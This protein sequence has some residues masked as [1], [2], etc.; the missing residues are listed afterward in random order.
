[1]DYELNLN[2]LKE[3]ELGILKKFDQICRENNLEYSLAYGTMLGAVR[4]HG[5]IPWD[6]DIDV[7]MKRDDYEKLM[8]LQYEDEQYEV[9]SYRYTK[10]YYYPF[11][12]MID[13]TTCL[14]E[15][16]RA[17]K[18]MGVYIDIFPLDLIN[19]FNEE[20]KATV[21]HNSSKK[22]YFA[23]LMG[24]KLS[25]HKAFKLRYIVKLSLL[26]F[27][28]PIKK[29]VIGTADKCVSKNSDGNYFVSFYSD[30]DIQF[31]N[32]EWLNNV[33]LVDFEC[34]YYPIYIDFDKILTQEYGDYMTP[35]PADKQVSNHYFK[36]Y[37][38][39]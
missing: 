18:N 22:I 36:A 2:E 13:K 29:L 17:E 37:K 31:I 19:I 30:T 4:H 9:K 12:K 14:N 15:P 33:S 11:S 38:K 24:H 25:H 20:D 28:Y 39:D 34:A 8:S 26:I 23:Y 35:P 1:M 5:F 3:I 21:I 27:T 16:W 7:F 10:G 6:D 32:K